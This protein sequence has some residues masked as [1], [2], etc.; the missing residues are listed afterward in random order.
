MATGNIN[1]HGC[2]TPQATIFLPYIF[3]PYS[4]YPFVPPASLRVFFSPYN[5]HSKTKGTASV[6]MEELLR[7]SLTSL[8][9][10]LKTRVCIYCRALPKRRLERVAHQK[11]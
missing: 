11:K 9:D 10:Q 8:R 1:G 6:Y 5:I 4:R 3:L 2:P 7:H